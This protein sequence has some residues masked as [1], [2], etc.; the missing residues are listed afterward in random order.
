MLDAYIIEKDIL[1]KD[2]QFNTF[3]IRPMTRENELIIK[4]DSRDK[5]TIREVAEHILVQVYDDWDEDRMEDS[6][7]EEE[8]NQDI[9][10]AFEIDKNLSLVNELDYYSIT[11]TR[12]IGIKVDGLA[13][14]K[15]EG[16]IDI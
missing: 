13:N 9:S 6:E 5:V 1:Y 10:D 2:G 8:M 4:L 7:N 15:T 14:L 16:T 12:G 3:Y 11:A